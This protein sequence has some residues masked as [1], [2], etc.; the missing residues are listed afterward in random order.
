MAKK[1]KQRSTRCSVEPGHLASSSGKT[2]R[3]YDVGALP[4]INRILKRMRL[5]AI[6]E[7][8]LP[9]DD[10]RTRMATHRGLLVLVRNILIAREPVYGVGEWAARYA[11]DQ[12]DLRHDHSVPSERAVWSRP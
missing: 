11:P 3:T 1:K 7:E 5:S 2:L 12:L 4:I 6:L 10:S 8:C 9:R